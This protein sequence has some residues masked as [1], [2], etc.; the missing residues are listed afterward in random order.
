LQLDLAWYIAFWLLAVA[1]ASAS[2]VT[3]EREEDTWISL[4]S[5]PLTGW[6]ILRAKALGAV[7]NQR[8]FG[9]VLV[10][11][12]L[13]ALVTGAVRPMGI[14][15]SIALVGV[16]TWLVAAVGIYFSMHAASTSRAL[17]STIVALSLFNGYPVILV[18]W[19]MGIISWNYSFTLLGFMPGVAVAPL[20]SP[21]FIAEPWWGAARPLAQYVNPLAFIPI[22]RLL[23][24]VAYSGSAAF[25][26]WRT[27]NRFDRWLD[28]P[29]LSAIH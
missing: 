25:L 7:W 4:T 24:V 19:F 20:M 11:V 9:A 14:L 15:A 5:T 22:G 13:T 6:Q 8:G 27:V 3:L 28:R 29:E 1:G 2:S 26:T 16:L 23:A 12:W 18:F 17:V 10:L 21:Q